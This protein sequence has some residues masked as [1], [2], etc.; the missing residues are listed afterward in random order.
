MKRLMLNPVLCINK[1]PECVHVCAHIRTIK[2]FSVKEGVLGAVQLYTEL[3]L[4]DT[5]CLFPD[6]GLSFSVPSNGLQVLAHR[7][8]YTAQQTV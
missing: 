5:D 3:F 1:T 6:S 7:R 8:L 2:Y 4:L